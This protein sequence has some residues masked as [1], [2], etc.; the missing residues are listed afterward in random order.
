MPAMELMVVSSLLQH[1]RVGRPHEQ[2]DASVTCMYNFATFLI[3][4]H[5]EKN[6]TWSN[7]TC[8]RSLLKTVLFRQRF[9]TAMATVPFHNNSEQ[10]NSV[11]C[12][13]KLLYNQPWNCW[14][15]QWEHG[16]KVFC[17]YSAIHYQQLYTEDLNSNSMLSSLY[18]LLECN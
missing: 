8:N 10:N 2:P 11:H 4:Q 9:R 18:L 1:T 17:K 15:R 12:T 6:L 16:I 3:L 13:I 5:R 7:S 14:R